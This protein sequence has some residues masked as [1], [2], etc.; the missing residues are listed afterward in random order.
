MANATTFEA[1]RAELMALAEA[2][3]NE[4]RYADFDG[5]KADI[6]KLDDEHKQEQKQFQKIRWKFCRIL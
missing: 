6:E 5:I 4:H 1:R 3:V 2:A